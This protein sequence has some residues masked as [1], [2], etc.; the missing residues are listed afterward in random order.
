MVYIGHG[1]PFAG[2][3]LAQ[4]YPARYQFRWWVR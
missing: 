2:D 4:I 3:R 1:E